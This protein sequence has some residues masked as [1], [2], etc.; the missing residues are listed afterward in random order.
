MK[1]WLRLPKVGVICLLTLVLAAM[2]SGVF[3]ENID[4]GNSNAQFAYGENVGW[5]NAEPSG[6]GGPGITVGATAPTG[7]MWG[8]N[9]GW[10]S[11]NCSNTSSCGTQSYGVTNSSGIL[12]GYAWGENV[13]W[14]SF[15]CANT[16]TCGTQNYGVTIVP[17]GVFTGNA[18]GE[19]TGWITFSASS[20]VAYQVRTGT[21]GDTDGDGRPDGEG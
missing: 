11:M 9:A 20:P 1:K 7:Y 10:V 12:S 19:N 3:A 5:L 4:P 8:E 17:G 13:G 6:D 16:G 14:I 15:S 2:A 18:W 21:T